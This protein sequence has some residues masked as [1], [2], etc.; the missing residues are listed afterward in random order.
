MESSRCKTCCQNSAGPLRQGWNKNRS[1]YMCVWLYF[2]LG[3]SKIHVEKMANWWKS[4]SLHIHASLEDQG[5][6]TYCM[7][8][9]MQMNMWV[10]NTQISISFL[11][12]HNAKTPTTKLQ[13]VESCGFHY[14]KFF[15]FSRYICFLFLLLFQSFFC[16]HLD[17]A[18][19][20][21]DSSQFWIGS[22]RKLDAFPHL[23]IS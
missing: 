12:L 22:E 1:L 20:V 10:G 3:I 19:P 8:K 21:L 2:T 15:L 23:N 16:F 17:T 7:C 14:A 4:A 9:N 5:T 13:S 18:K 11:S 6:M